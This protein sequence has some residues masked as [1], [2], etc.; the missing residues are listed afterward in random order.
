M[1]ALLAVS[2]S[3]VAGVA[4]AGALVAAG[5]LA[6]RSSRSGASSSASSTTVW[7]KST[8][9][10]A[11]FAVGIWVSFILYGEALGRITQTEF[12]LSP[13]NDTHKAT[14]ERFETTDVLVVFQS[15]RVLSRAR[16]AFCV[17][18]R[19]GC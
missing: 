13:A 3:T 15:V 9:A 10:M 18:R 12:V 17:S 6:L 1:A 2:T 4:T 19:A 5:A 16:S 14:T 8:P 7:M 11:F